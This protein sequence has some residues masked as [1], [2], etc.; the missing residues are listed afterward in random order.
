MMKFFRKYNKT[1]MAVLMA[2]LM[3]V[4]I[5]G[6]ALQGMLT[7]STDR[8]VAT[9]S[10]GEITLL[11]QQEV[12][13]M[14]EMIATMGMTW[15]QPVQLGY[16]K[17]L[18][19]IDWILLI[20]ETERLGL[21]LE[22]A[23][24][25]AAFQADQLEQ[26]SRRAKVKVEDLVEAARLYQSVRGAALT[27]V[28]ASAPGEGEIRSLARDVLE[29]VQIN[30]VMLP[31][32]MLLDE[33]QEF[34]E[35]QIQAQFESGKAKERGAGLEF[36]YYR[37]PT[38]K[39]QF[40]SIDRDK[41]A[42]MVGVANLESKS[43]KLYDEMVQRSDRIIQRPAVELE[44]VGD[45]PELPALLSWEEA[46]EAVTQEVRRAQ[47]DQTAERIANWLIQRAGT[48]WLNSER[49]ENG[50]RMTPEKVA[51]SGY[52]RD[53]L[54]RLPRELNYPDAITVSE[55]S[56]FTQEN[57]VDIPYIGYSKY[58]PKRGIPTPFSKLAF[59]N[60]G[61]VPE[62]TTDTP[63]RSDYLAMYETCAYPLTN[64]IN[65][66]RYVFRVVATEAGRPAKSADEVRDEI[67]ADLR[68]QA[69]YDSALG[70]AG[71]L[72]SCAV[73]E[74]LQEGYDTNLELVALRDTKEGADSGF[75][76]PPPFSRL[77]SYQA[78]SGRP[79]RGVFVGGGLG[80]IS[81]DAV[82]ACFALAEGGE[83]VVILPMPERAE[84]VVAEL[85]QVNAPIEEDFLDTRTQLIADV[86]SKRASEV[87]QNWLS[88]EQIRA[89]NQLELVT[90]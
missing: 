37:H 34:T 14:T 41:L 51:E 63:N 15:Q 54:G 38:T 40:V 65:G 44:A 56:Y 43:K 28:A 12:S 13:R 87:I 61:I 71:S 10:L 90:R 39:V 57:A 27:F 84:V 45:G 59:L 88:S 77:R 64:P 70:F 73:G 29:M 89:R 67:V 1:M 58:S 49:G 2:L 24:V 19:E 83:R 76:Q 31:A 17:P 69:A 23:N 68:L 8:V 36:G 52:Y 7:P 6:S 79:D 5:G 48:A 85:V 35:A 60:E 86:R 53:L 25:R 11:D 42:G 4:F 75:I 16:S 3:V 55:S 47:A 33:G 78:A 21:M 62:I 72:H 26:L 18:E 32:K 81:N 80:L 74:G 30:A 22:S 82:D 20:R 9:S 46:K 66:A 50:Y